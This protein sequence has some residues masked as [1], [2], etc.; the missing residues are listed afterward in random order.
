[1][2]V[3]E[4]VTAN[5]SLFGV[6]VT[7]TPPRGGTAVAVAK[8]L[9]REEEPQTVETEGG[10]RILRRATVDVDVND[11]A[12]PERDATV[13]YNSETWTVIAARP[14]A[15][16]VNRLDLVIADARTAARNYYQR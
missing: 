12:A 9:W 11:V 13:I 8:A 15:E 10:E 1:M 16:A 2:D 14:I 5:M 6:A 3:S 4:M 7:Y